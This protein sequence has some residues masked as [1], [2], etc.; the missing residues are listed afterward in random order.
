MDCPNAASKA[1]SCDA[2]SVLASGAFECS[3]MKRRLKPVFRNGRMKAP[4][5]KQQ[6]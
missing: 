6:F 2:F 1:P 4:T 5:L 3:P